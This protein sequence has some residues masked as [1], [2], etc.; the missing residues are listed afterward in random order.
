LNLLGDVQIAVD[1]VACEL[2]KALVYKGMMFSGVPNLASTFGYTNASWTLKADLTARYVCRLLARMDATG[3]AVAVPVRD[4]S[5][6]EQPFLDF[7]SGYVQRAVAMLPKQGDRKPWRLAQNY[8]VD[9]AVLRFSPL[10]DS[11]MRFTRQG[12]PLPG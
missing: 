10:Q 1:G 9:L 11:V 12:Q 6:R 2:S 5:V 3:D 8:I 4:P 7:S